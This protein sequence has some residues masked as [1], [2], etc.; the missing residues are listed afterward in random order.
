MLENQDAKTANYEVLSVEL[1]SIMQ[2][3]NKEVERLE[4][5]LKTSNNE[6]RKLQRQSI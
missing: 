1:N 6:I 4:T 5:Q 2:N 3:Q